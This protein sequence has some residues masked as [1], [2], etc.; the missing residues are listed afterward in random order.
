MFEADASEPFGRVD[1]SQLEATASAYRQPRRVVSSAPSP[2]QQYGYAQA[3]HSWLRGIIS[4]DDEV[5]NAFNITYDLVGNDEYA[6]NLTLVPNGQLS[7]FKPGAIVEVRGRVDKITTTP[8]GK[9][10]YR[11][12]SVKL[13]SSGL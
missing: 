7:Q 12:T 8:L 4:P 9:P 2:T 1:S 3:D 13:I 6:G 5:P 10:M 11:I